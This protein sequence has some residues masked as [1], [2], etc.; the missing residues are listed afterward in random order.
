MMKNKKQ[1]F[2]FLFWIL[3]VLVIVIVFFGSIFFGTGTIFAI[4]VGLIA[5]L[6]HKLYSRKFS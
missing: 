6:I 1:E 4:I 3:L 5:L 2:D